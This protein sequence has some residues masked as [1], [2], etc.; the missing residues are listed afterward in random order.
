MQTPGQGRHTGT[1]DCLGNSILKNHLSLGYL[2]KGTHT[3]QQR[4]ENREKITEFTQKAF[5]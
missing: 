1:I 3:K 2:G 5:S 4:K